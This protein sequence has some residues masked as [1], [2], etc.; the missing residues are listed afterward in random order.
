MQLIQQNTKP[1]QMPR[2]QRRK[3]SC[4][5]LTEILLPYA[6]FEHLSMILP[7]L[8]HL[9]QHADPGKWFTWIS[10]DGVEKH[11]LTQ[12]QF[13]L[14]NIQLI[15]TRSPKESLWALWES[16]RSG[17]SDVVVATCKGISKEQYASLN[18][19]AIHGDTQGLVISYPAS[20]DIES[21]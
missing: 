3:H 20:S 12:Y 19:A 16:L 14:D 18:T 4:A 6:G 9:S 8:A 17:R 21:L 13:K 2:L 11:H 15:H 5:G 1:A 7:M 10:P